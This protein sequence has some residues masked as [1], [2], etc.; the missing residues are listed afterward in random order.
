MPDFVV[1]LFLL[2]VLV[3]LCFFDLARSEHNESL[4]GVSDQDWLEES[5]DK[6]NLTISPYFDNGAAQR[7]Q[8]FGPCFGPVVFRSSVPRTRGPCNVLC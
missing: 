3:G 2:L 4:A 7:R 5:F 6:Q 1:L 8:C